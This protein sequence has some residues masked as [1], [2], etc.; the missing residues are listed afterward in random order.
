MQFAPVV[1]NENVFLKKNEEKE[2]G[3]K[4]KNKKDQTQHL[5]PSYR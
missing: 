3:R 2:E 1:I 4:E 5:V